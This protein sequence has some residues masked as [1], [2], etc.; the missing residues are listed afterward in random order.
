MKEKYK[1]W[2]ISQRAE[3][4]ANVAAS[5]FHTFC[6]PKFRGPKWKPEDVPHV[7]ASQAKIQCLM[8][9]MHPKHHDQVVSMAV[10][11]YNR[12]LAQAMQEYHGELPS[13]Q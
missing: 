1:R 2:T 5:N 8:A 3:L 9:C 13:N 6:D 7:I 10:D 4:A 11:F 12:Y